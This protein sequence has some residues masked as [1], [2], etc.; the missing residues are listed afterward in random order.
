MKNPRNI[1]AL[2]FDFDD[3]LTNDSTTL[4]LQ[5]HG[6]DTNKFWKEEVEKRVE[7]EWD[8]TLAYLDLILS[9]VGEGKSL[10]LLSNRELREF[11]SKLKIYPGIPKLFKDLQNICS[12]HEEF[13]NPKMEYYII[14]G[15]LEEIILG[16]RIAKLFNGIWGCRFHEKNGCIYKIKNVI[17]FTEKTKF[18]F[19]INKG[20]HKD[21]RKKPY[22]VNNEK[23]QEERRVPF[24]NI[25]Y[26]GDG[27]TDVPCFS[28]VQNM[29]KRQNNVFGVFDPKRKN[30]DSPKQDWVI[31]IAPERV[32]S[33]NSPCFGPKDDLGYLIRNA[34]ES[35]CTALDKELTSAV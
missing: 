18:L 2:S 31:K 8:P 15:G 29:S 25:I 33:L 3:T 11:G 16:C 21:I 34:V 12:K 9:Y 26:V 30:V 13:S 22:I 5:K 27:L 32:A 19:A 17:S 14:S 20:L 23:K 1:I 35:I 10:G 7:K 28:L 24:K 6:I 4:L